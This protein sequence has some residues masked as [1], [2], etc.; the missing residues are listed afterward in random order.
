MKYS[1]EFNIVQSNEYANLVEERGYDGCGMRGE[2]NGMYGKTHTPEAR[3]KIS[4][5]RKSAPTDAYRGKRNAMY[6]KIGELNPFFGKFHSDETKQKMRKPRSVALPVVYCIYC[7]RGISVN[8]FG[9]HLKGKK[10]S[11]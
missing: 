10:C 4:E 6:G 1:N 9:Q 7:H 3:N 5:A 8:A 11:N 2:Q